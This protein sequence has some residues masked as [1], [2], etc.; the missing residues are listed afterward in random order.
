MIKET[1]IENLPLSAPVFE[2]FYTGRAKDGKYTYLMPQI[3]AKGLTPLG[4]A[5][6]MTQRVVAPESVRDNWLNNYFFTVD[7]NPCHPDGRFKFVP[8][9]SLLRAITSET[10]LV[11]GSIPLNDGVYE[12]LQGTEFSATDRKFTGKNLTE[13]EAK[14]D[15]FWHAF[16]RGNQELQ[17]AYVEKIFK[18][19]RD[20]YKTDTGMPVFPGSIPKTPSLRA[21]LVDRV[22]DCDGSAAY[23]NG[24]LDYDYSRLVA[25]VGAGGAV[26]ELPRSGTHENLESVLGTTLQ[27]S[28]DTGKP[29]EYQGK[30]YFSVDKSDIPV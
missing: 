14:K 29:F 5:G 26:K 18:V 15:P 3:I 9:C 28:L 7:G 21:W 13:T 23:G 27:Q 4:M 20:V 22:V 8:D 10:V 16:S 24:D 17:D 2:S 30:V 19:L 1:H 25:V 6:V 11:N 12:S